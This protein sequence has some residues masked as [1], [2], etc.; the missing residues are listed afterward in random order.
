MFDLRK[1]V[2][3]GVAA[4]TLGLGASATLTPAAA[5]EI[6]TGFNNGGWAVGGTPVPAGLPWAVATTYYSP[7]YLVDGYGNVVSYHIVRICDQA[8]GSH[9]NLFACFCHNQST[10]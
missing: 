5:Y 6:S 7:C 9:E 3:I 10:A 8:H 4:S 2:A 1:A